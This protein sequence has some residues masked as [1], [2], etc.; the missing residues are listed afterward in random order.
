MSAMQQGEM[1][2]VAGMVASADDWRLVKALRSGDETAFVSLLDRYHAS[3]TRLAA[4]YVPDHATAEEVVQETWIG[5]LKSIHRFEGRSSLKTWIYG[6][7]T[8][9][10]RTRGR[11]EDRSI[12]FSALWDPDA[13]SHEPA[14]EPEQ[15]RPPSDKW[16]GG[17]VSSL[18]SWADL[19]EDHLL[20]QETLAVVRQAIE[21]LRPS[22]REVITLRD[23]EGWTAEEVCNALGIT[24]TNQRVLLHR[25]RSSVR[26]ALD[27]YLKA[28]T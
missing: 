2:E 1:A 8:H 9:C 6:I 15:F 11:R 28:H 16:A 19:P 18:Q 24:E 12:P 3:L 13:E 21:Q 23:I 20:S 25:A 26:R 4:M 17:W 14:V 10:A 7:L 22:Q 27:Q 5:V